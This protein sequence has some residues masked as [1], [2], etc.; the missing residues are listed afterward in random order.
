MIQQ[1]V[2]ICQ[3]QGKR[4]A[5]QRVTVQIMQILKKDHDDPIKYFTSALDK[6]KPLVNIH[7]LY[8]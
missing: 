4:A 8:L 7:F 2:G 5:A 6:L 3:K 1:F